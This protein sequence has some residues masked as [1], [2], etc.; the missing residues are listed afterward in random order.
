MEKSKNVN[1]ILRAEKKAKDLMKDF[2][3]FAVKG[4]I[5]D[6]AT[7]VIIGTAF[8]KIV[9]SLVSEIIT[10]A[11]SLLTG[12]MNVSSFFI[13]IS[14]QHFATIEEAKAA[15]VATINYGLF[16]S[17]IIDF[18]IVAFTIF[19][20]LRYTFK[21]RE[22]EI[23][24]EASKKIP[25]TKE[26]PYCLSTIPEKAVKCAFCTETLLVRKNAEK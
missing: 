8:T 18:L 14:S 12:K 2:K 19:L 16:L 4:N 11:M 9:N 5:V 7:G 10:P 15:G 13:P 3:S 17:S 26:C 24:A 6:M 22:K 20:V 23:A 21:R 25:P 1:K